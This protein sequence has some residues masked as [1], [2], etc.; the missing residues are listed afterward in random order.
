MADVTSTQAEIDAQRRQALEDMAQL[1][2]RTQQ[3]N[4][5]QGDALNSQATAN[6]AYS[7]QAAADINAPDALRAS[8]ASQNSYTLGQGAEQ[9][10]NSR[11]RGE[12]YQSATQNE[13]ELYFD[14]LSGLV[15]LYQQAAE[16]AAA[17]RGGGGGGGSGGGGGGGSTNQGGFLN[18]GQSAD[19]IQKVGL[20]LADQ[21]RGRQK[22][23]ALGK[24]SRS[25]AVASGVINK[26]KKAKSARD[27]AARN[28][29]LTNNRFQ[30]QAEAAHRGITHGTDRP[31]ML[32]GGRYFIDGGASTGV[33]PLPA[34]RGLI[35]KIAERVANT[36]LDRAREEQVTAARRIPA[37]IGNQLR[38]NLDALRFADPIEANW[39]FS[40]DR[41][42][43]AQEQLAATQYPVDPIAA[44]AAFAESYFRPIP[45]QQPQTPNLTDVI[46]T[47]PQYQEGSSL[48]QQAAMQ[49]YS[50]QYVQQQL[51]QLGYPPEVL[52][53]LI[54]DQFN[55]LPY[56]DEYQYEAP[57]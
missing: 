12:Q 42:A 35:D 33:R 43:L 22:G 24:Q 25:N 45:Q 19:E 18:Q 6:A 10:N 11:A 29:N 8:M 47:T 3:A 27:R 13:N 48:I 39:P 36:E 30:E 51:N 49:G 52:S 1:G 55:I 44:Q 7:Q 57:E 31:R 15:P 4:Q 41:I 46:R 38:S 16:A 40:N 14:R 21:E 20:A 26:A 54:T 23:A 9:L 34:R 56:D 50:S 32:P 17:A 2:Y 53:Q 37:A 5:R 28:R